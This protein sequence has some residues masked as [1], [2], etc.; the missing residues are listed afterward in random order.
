MATKRVTETARGKRRPSGPKRHRATE[1]R[2]AKAEGGDVQ[3]RPKG[4]PKAQLP[5]KARTT[6]V[7]P[8]AKGAPSPKSKSGQPRATLETAEHHESRKRH[9]A[10]RVGK[11]RKTEVEAAGPKTDHRSR[12]ARH[13]LRNQARAQGR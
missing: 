13:K 4:I 1:K 5:M 2:S 12:Q 11:A 3:H 7:K 9:H 6:K 8:K 10:R